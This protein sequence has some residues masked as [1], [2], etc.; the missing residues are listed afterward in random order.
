MKKFIVI[1]LLALATIP[2]IAQHRHGHYHG[3]YHGY[4]S[5]GLAP[6]IG[7][8]VLGAV[9]YDV[10]NRPVV[11]QQPPVVVQQQP[12]VVQQQSGCTSWKEIQSAD[13]TI[14]RERTCYGIQQ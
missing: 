12:I 5:S 6:W 7:G 11:V 4:R 10:Y 2:A 8:A 14:Y 1:T 3:Q 9:I 13:G